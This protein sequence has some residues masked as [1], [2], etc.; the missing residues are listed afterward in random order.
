[1]E[2]HN[3]ELILPIPDRQYGDD[4]YTFL[5]TLLK[6]DDIRYLSRERVQS[7]FLKDVKSYLE[8][9]ASPKR[10]TINWHDAEK[11]PPGTYPADYR[12]NGTKAKPVFVFA[13]NTE[14][15][16][17]VATISLMK[18]EQWKLDYRSVGIFDDME[19]FSPK[20][21]ARFSDACQ[22]TYSS[23]EAAKETLPRYVPELVSSDS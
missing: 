16:A 14:H 18:F 22:K 4:L 7:T 19:K 10:I 3:G 12:I 17:D 1:V 6:I 21:I 15:K 13:I 23:L 5:Q 20:T 11:D 8:K 9:T 2:N